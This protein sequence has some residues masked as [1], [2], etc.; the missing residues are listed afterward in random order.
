MPIDTD[1][2]PGADDDDDLPYNA[3]DFD[4]F[5]SKD[6]S[7]DVIDT[8]DGGAIIRLSD[9]EQD[10]ANGEFYANLVDELDRSV[11]SGLGTQLLDRIEKDQDARAKRDKQYEEGLRRTGLGEDAPGGASFE[12][13]SKVVHPMLIEACIDFAARAMKEI[14]PAAGPAKSYIPGKPTEDRMEKAARKT[15]LLNWQLTVQ[16]QNA[17]A[18]IE[19][20]M[21]QLPMGGSQYTKVWWDEGKNRPEVL[22]VPIDDMFLPFAATN[23]YSAQR[24]THR[25]YV[26]QLEYERKVR[27]GEWAD[28]DLIPVGMEPEQSATAV[29][30]DKIEGRESTSYNEDGLRE[31]FSC[32]AQVEIEGD[33]LAGDGAAPYLVVIDKATRKVLAVYRNWLEDDESREELQWFVEW[34]F[35]P[36]RGAYALGLPH[37]M[38]GLSGAATGALRALLDSAHINNIPSGLKLK[39]KVGGQTTSMSATQIAEVE[40]GINIDDIRKLYMPLPF[41]PPS[42]VLFQLLG[43]LVDAGKSVIQTSLENIAD[44]NPNAPV[45]TTL[46]QIEQG[47]VVFSS[48]HSRLHDAMAR[49]LRIM[50]RLNGQYL[51]DEALLDEAGNELA[52]R[53][54]FQGPLDVVPVSDPNIFSEAQRFAQ[55]QAVQQRATQMPQ[56][57]DLRRVEERF[58]ET[59]RIP[60]ADELL[61]PNT[62]PVEE[63]AVRENVFATLGRPL[64]A[65][66]KQDH[67]AHL[68]THLSF[69]ASPMY[70]M[71]QLIAPAALPILVEHVKQHMVMWYQAAIFAAIEQ[72]SGIDADE[73][74]GK[75][76]TTAQKQAFDRMLAE[77]AVAI[78]AEAPDAFA[79]LQPVIQQ[80]QQ[81]IQ[82]LQGPQAQ[83]P[84]DPGAVAMAD[85]QRR[86]AADQT[87]AQL[88]SQQLTN[89]QAEGEAKRSADMAK[90]SLIEDRE[91]QRLAAKIMADQQMNEDDNATSMELASAKHVHELYSKAIEP[92]PAPPAPRGPE[93]LRNG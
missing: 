30:N 79:E 50:H 35:V 65:M 72:V 9:E 15:A 41:N 32:Y 28:A 25:E 82:Q 84:V 18:E 14:F 88:K 78:I 66:P 26:T 91:D 48:I 4:A 19:Q 49:M 43:F 93:G 92:P 75:L 58:L 27:S 16:V 67:I 62:D 11:V 59:L 73:E 70:G 40:G 46:A 44:Q 61:A 29:A 39:S 71:S 37:I 55:A 22:F 68:K 89:Q 21:T 86:A 47:M 69:M 64:V 17:R 51:D 57:Y 74:R 53:E 77:A 8:P 33:D 7:N 31:V 85:V 80:A 52:S 6:S 36:W 20:T 54:D 23:F 13:A 5:A 38:G 81:L 90:Q 10:A 63:N 83:P 34:P 1:D 24:K 60:N 56:L 2:L 42:T 3:G 45:G 87:N 12:G 76:K